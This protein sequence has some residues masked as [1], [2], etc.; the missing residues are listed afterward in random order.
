MFFDLL[1]VEKTADFDE[2]MKYLLENVDPLPGDAA[3]EEVDGVVIWRPLWHETIKHKVNAQFVDEVVLKIW[4]NET[5]GINLHKLRM[6]YGKL[7]CCRTNATTRRP[8]RRWMTPTTIAK[9][10]RP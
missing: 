1:G 10:L 4:T 3:K 6:V 5:V 7:T 2:R 9:S 8:N